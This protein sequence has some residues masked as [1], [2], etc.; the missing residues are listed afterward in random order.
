MARVS[1]EKIDLDN[2]VVHAFFEQRGQ[3]YDPS[4]PFT[5]VLYQDNNPE[6]AHKRDI[7]EKSK[8]LPTLNLS[9]GMNVLDIGCGI[10]RWA[11]A[12]APLVSSYVGTDISE[13]LLRIARERSEYLP[14]TS[15]HTVGAG[16]LSQL[17]ANDIQGFDL[18]IIAGV[19]IYLNDEDIISCLRD[20]GN[21]AKPNCLIYLREPIAMT[22]RLT[23]KDFWSEDL[24]QN[25]SAIYRTI[26]E[27]DKLFGA[28]LYKNGF[29]AVQFHKLYED[30]LNN[31]TE[32]VQHYAMIERQQ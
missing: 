19:F 18:I 31:R 15:F 17:A 1:K 7:Y 20:I 12:I 23:L 29:D 5:S 10:G 24:D 27:L 2:K 9:V 8:I 13:A 28:S 25:Y 22:D 14:N 11:S 6:L 30:G 16:N 26:S 32:T 21:L 4:A 3:K